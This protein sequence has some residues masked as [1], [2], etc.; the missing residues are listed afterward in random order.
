MLTRCAVS[1]GG[2]DFFRIRVLR[3]DYSR[4]HEG[5]EYFL[6]VPPASLQCLCIFGFVC[7]A[8]CCDPTFIAYPHDLPVVWYLYC[9]FSM[10]GIWSCVFHVAF[11]MI[12]RSIPAQVLPVAPRRVAVVAVFSPIPRFLRLF[13]DFCS[14]AALLSGGP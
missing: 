13:W 6:V 8:W 3:F 7:V 2:T 9:F 4:V 10:C 1:G 5:F 11:A 14:A 12:T